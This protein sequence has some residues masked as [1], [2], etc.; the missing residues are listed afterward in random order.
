[1]FRC[2]SFCVGFW[3]FVFIKERDGLLVGGFV[4]SGFCFFVEW[5]MYS[6]EYSCVS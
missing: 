4:I 6:F 3:I 1:M 5:Y 2:F